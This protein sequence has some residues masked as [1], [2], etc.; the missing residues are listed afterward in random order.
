MAWHLVTIMTE[1]RGGERQTFQRRE[2]AG[3]RPVLLR[4]VRRE[5]HFH[6]NGNVSCV[7]RLLLHAKIYAMMVFQMRRKLAVD[8]Y[9]I[10][11]RCLSCNH[12]WEL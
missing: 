7:P 1:L 4:R 3:V 5:S 10:L 11:L 12:R 6:A 8:R 9:K 2:F